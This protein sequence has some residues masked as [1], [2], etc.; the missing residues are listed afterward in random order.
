MRDR[1]VLPLLVLTGAAMIA[2][3][4]VWP[5]G[6]GAPS[7]KPFTR[8]LAAVPA[9]KPSIPAGIA[10]KIADPN[11]VA[12]AT[13]KA[14]GKPIPKPKKPESADKAGLRPAQ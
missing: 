2:L 6:L 7:P 5:Q 11:A 8:P 4:L 10:A 3:S 12:R 9:D 1:F 14:T 13:A